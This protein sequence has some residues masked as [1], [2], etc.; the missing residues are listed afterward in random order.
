MGVFDRIIEAAKVVYSGYEHPKYAHDQCSEVASVLR[1]VFDIAKV[2]ASLASAEITIKDDS[3]HYGS[4]GPCHSS[5]IHGH[6]FVVAEN[7]IVD[8]TLAQFYPD[9]EWPFIAPLDSKRAKKVYSKITINDAD[10]D[11]ELEGSR[12]VERILQLAKID[13]A[14][15]KACVIAALK[16]IVAEDKIPGPKWVKPS[17]ATFKKEMRNEDEEIA[18][19]FE[20]T[21]G[22]LEALYSKAY[23]KEF[24]VD[25]VKKIDIAEGDVPPREW[26]LNPKIKPDYKDYELG[27]GYG[28]RY[29]PRH[30]KDV[31]PAF[32]FGKELDIPILY[33]FK[34][35][36]KYQALCGRHRIVYAIALELPIK[37]LIIDWSYCDKISSRE[38]AVLKKIAAKDNPDHKIKDFRSKL[39][40]ELGISLDLYYLRN[41]DAM[42]LSRIVVPKESR[43]EGVGTKAMEKISNFADENGLITV[44]SPSTDFG[45]T[46]VDRLRKFYSRFGFVRN[47]GRHKDFRFTQT[48]I[49]HPKRR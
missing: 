39:E 45:G 20:K 37:A 44:L 10:W 41:Q 13:T 31:I 33:Y 4:Y 9:E 30:Q 26:L 14:G 46:S 6:N 1:N 23:V 36:N 17:F 48:M 21:P 2:K 18:K 24:T 25:E 35:K 16:K 12:E 32:R 43:K 47:F 34:R 42:E 40:S 15:P 27:D 5:G 38:T 28:Y 11:W 7:K 8:F 29:L 3:P 49:R 19:V 22:G